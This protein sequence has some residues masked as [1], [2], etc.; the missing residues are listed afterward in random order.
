[1][2]LIVQVPR[3]T[4]PEEWSFLTERH[5]HFLVEVNKTMIIIL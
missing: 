5:A 4:R 1:M 2:M 3:A